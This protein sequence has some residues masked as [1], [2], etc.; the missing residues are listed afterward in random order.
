MSSGSLEL[1]FEKEGRGPP[2]VFLHGLFGSGENWRSQAKWL[3]PWFTVYRVDL[4][5]HGRSPHSGEVGYEHM[6]EDVLEFLERHDL[7]RVILLGHSMG[8]KV[9]MGMALSFPDWVEKLVVVDMA[10]REYPPLN[11]P[12]FEALLSVDLGTCR[13]R[14]DVDRALKEKMPELRLRAFVLK[15]LVE[16][17]GRV[18]W[19]FNLEGLW[20]GYP[21]ILANIELEDRVYPGPTLMLRGA[22]SPYVRETD[23]QVCARHFP[24]QRVITLEGAGHWPHADKARDFHQRVKEFLLPA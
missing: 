4:R 16:E 24:A 7:R 9:A 20:R 15:S 11:K 1:F 18:R 3:E 8:G 23:L 12:I 21:E 5:N 17:D 22:L 6:V 19:M 14:A 2:L 13:S 10:P